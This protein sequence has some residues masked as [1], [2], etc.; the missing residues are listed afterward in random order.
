MSTY[1]RE[2]KHPVTGNWE[3]ATWYDDL[4]G[5]H[6]YG[7]V[8]PSDLKRAKKALKGAEPMLANIAFDPR[9]VE[10]E[11]RTAPEQPEPGMSEQLIA[12]RQALA[13]YMQAEGCS[14]C[15]NETQHHEAAEK[16]AY[17]L[18]VP[19]YTDASGYDF[20]QFATKPV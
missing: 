13:D 14:C 8:F 15:R 1:N 7:V 19:M 11:T 4:L 3:N 5:H 10:L 20:N 6:N 17:L 16:L 12:I 9:R 18:G 2:T